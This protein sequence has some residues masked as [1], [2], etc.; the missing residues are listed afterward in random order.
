VAAS[1]SLHR[2]RGC[3][4]D[5]RVFPIPTRPLPF[6]EVVLFHLGEVRPDGPFGPGVI[7]FLCVVVVDFA[8]SER[9]VL[10]NDVV[11]CPLM[12]GEGIEALLLDLGS[13]I[14][15]GVQEDVV[16]DALNSCTQTYMEYT[17]TH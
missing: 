16:G 8:R 6:E 5:E 13:S 17:K 1:R 10:A 12:G 4:I 7:D 14:L 9:A 2:R 11:D 3:R 15:G